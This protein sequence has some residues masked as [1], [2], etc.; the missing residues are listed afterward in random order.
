VPRADIKSE[1]AALMLSEI[2]AELAGKL[3]DNR[4]A[5]IKIR[6]PRGGLKRFVKCSKES[7]ISPQSIR[8]ELAD[9]GVD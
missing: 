9:A 6:T 3:L 2:R 7:M 5:A 8:A 4:R 1:Q